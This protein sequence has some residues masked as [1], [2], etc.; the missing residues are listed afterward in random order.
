MATFKILFNRKNKLNAQKQAV[1]SIEVYHKSKRKIISTGVFI[2]PRFWDQKNNLVKSSHPDSFRYNTIIKDKLN[3]LKN[4][5]LETVLKNKPFSLEMIDAQNKYLSFTDYFIKTI[6]SR[7]SLRLNTRLTHIT[8]YNVFKKFAGD[9]TFKQLTYKLIFDYDNYLRSRYKDY[10]VHTKQKILR[11]YINF[12]IKQGLME[13]ND[14]PYRNFKLKPG[15]SNRIDLS[16]EQLHK[17]ENLQIPDETLNHIRDL[18]LFSCYTG[19]RFEDVMDLTHSDIRRN[20]K[21]DVEINKT[22]IKTEEKIRLPISILFAGKALRIIEKY[23]NMHTEKLLPQYTNQAV[24]R[25][26]K[27]LSTLINYNFPLTFHIA[28]HTF[29]SRMAEIKPDPYLIQELMGHKDIKTSMD[30][31]KTSGDVLEDKLRN[32]KW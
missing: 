22:I 20:R 32:T 1:V 3:A 27:A 12:A 31:I 5:E 21:G 4:I 17:L 25:L 7:K 24:N 29:G 30:Y 28:R 9:V 2:E 19:L 13:A 23:K 10:T 18:F 14:Y 15:K 8:A 11:T 6:E 26:L 16:Y